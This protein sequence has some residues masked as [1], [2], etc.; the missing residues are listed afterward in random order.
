MAALAD[1][2]RCYASGVRSASVPKPNRAVAGRIPLRS[3]CI[4][5]DQD[6]AALD[7]GGCR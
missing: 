6:N 3:G 7:Q 5:P 4:E 1:L 2:R